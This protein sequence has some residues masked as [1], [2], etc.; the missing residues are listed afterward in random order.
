MAKKRDRS[1]TDRAV[2]L[3][4]EQQRAWLAFMRVQLRMEY[5]MNRQLQADSGL[6]LSDYHVLVALSDN[7]G[8]MRVGDLAAHIGWERSRV[9]HQLR[10]ME[11]RGL[12]LRQ[13]GAED[14]RTT[15]VVL[16]KQGRAAIED[17]APAHVDLVRRLF[18]DALPDPLLGPFTTALEHIH[19]NLNLNSSLPPAPH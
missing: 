10:R 19:V 6:S 8:G 17:A 4:A 2:W 1:P 9:S 11:Q 16:T 7:P 13:A 18:F 14:A 5:E 12:T 15:N 3:T